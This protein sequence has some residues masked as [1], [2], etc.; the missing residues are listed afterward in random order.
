METSTPSRKGRP[1][2][3][4]VEAALDKAIEIFWLHGY[5]AAS[6]ALL[7]KAMGINPPSLYAAFGCKEQLFRQALDHYE[8]RSQAAAAQALAHPEL[9][10][11]LAA[12][13]AL[14]LDTQASDT[15]PRGCLVVQ[16]VG[17]C[18]ESEEAVFA[19]LKRRRLAVEGVLAQ[20]LTQA[21]DAGQ[22]RVETSP[23]AGA[24]FL[25][26]QIRGIS[27]LARDG[28]TR[29]QLQPVVDLAI[30]AVVA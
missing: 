25:S 14:V 18:G 26:A 10:Q 5:E 16:G 29:E 6:I 4:D 12:F 1:R 27:S 3:F 20:R 9:R 11:A 2:A 22:L 24:R 30:Q 23:E 8:A 19:E 28:T 21:Q 13:F 17:S 7:T 15:R